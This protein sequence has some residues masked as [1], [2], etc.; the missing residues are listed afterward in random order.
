MTQLQARAI[1]NA[2][3]KFN[4]ARNELRIHRLSETAYRGVPTIAERK[5]AAEVHGTFIYRG[6][7]YIK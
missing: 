5:E 2:R 6:R 1:Q 3:N 4:R 7:T